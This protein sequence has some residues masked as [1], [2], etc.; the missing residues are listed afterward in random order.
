MASVVPWKGRWT[1]LVTAGSLEAEGEYVT[2]RDAVAVF[3]APEGGEA[4]H[5]VGEGGGR[6]R[7]GGRVSRGDLIFSMNHGGPSLFAPHSTFRL[8][9]GQTERDSVAPTPGR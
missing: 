6:S 1:P 2:R 3:R 4:R 8:H 5:H 9:G 7:A